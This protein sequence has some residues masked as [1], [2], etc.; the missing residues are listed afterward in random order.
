MKF[1]E[2]QISK[3]LEE[4]TPSIVEGFKKELTD[5]IS[6]DVRNTAAE[7]VKRKTTE[8]VEENIFPEIEKQLIESKDGLISLAGS[9]GPEIVEMVTASLILQLKERL[10]KSWERSKILKAMFD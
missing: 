7:L 3:M 2:E 5:S 10:E 1:T 6:W 4:A 9:F 8:W